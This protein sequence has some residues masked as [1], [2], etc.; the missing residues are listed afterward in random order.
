MK[1][2]GTIKKV[3][4][5]VNITDSFAKK[6]IV[7]TTAEQYPQDILVQFVNDQIDPLYDL[8]EG[9]EVEVSINIR[10]REWTSPQGEI[11]YFNTI[12]GWK[13][14]KTNASTEQAPPIAVA[15]GFTTAKTD[16]EDD[17]PF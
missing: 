16:E 6:E 3:F 10:G 17:L 7:V 5:T 1:I 4:E 12:Q 2:K 14:E 9:E 13:I 11:K 8:K 15:Q